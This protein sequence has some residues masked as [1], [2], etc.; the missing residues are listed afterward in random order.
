[1][2]SLTG[3]NVWAANVFPRTTRRSHMM[4]AGASLEN[5]LN[6][7]W[8]RN[9]N[10]T[11]G[12]GDRWQCS[13]QQCLCR[14][15]CACVCLCAC[16][17]CQSVDAFLPHY[18]A[19]QKESLLQHDTPPYTTQRARE[20]KRQT[21]RERDMDHAFPP[22]HMHAAAAAQRIH[23]AATAPERASVQTFRQRFEAKIGPTASCMHCRPPCSRR[24]CTETDTGAADGRKPH[25]GGGREPLTQRGA[26][27]GL[28]TALWLAAPPPAAART[29]RQCP[30]R[31]PAASPAHNPPNPHTTTTTHNTHTRCY[32]H[33]SSGDDCGTPRRVPA[34]PGGAAGRS[35]PVCT[36]CTRHSLLESGVSAHN[37]TQ[38]TAK[39][40]CLGEKGGGAGHCCPL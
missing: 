18:T 12:G 27:W 17:L 4:L 29:H 25:R 33:C 24:Q 3:V 5:T 6:G 19:A 37:P 35:H 36:K 11:A 14:C 23:R 30:L 10:R 39:G 8:T 21:K 26:P 31:L 15:V 16:R 20:T 9:V 22:P 28:C 34:G 38:N 13:C 32:T 2:A 40:R 1:M 7:H